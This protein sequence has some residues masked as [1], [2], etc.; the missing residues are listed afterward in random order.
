MQKEK[1]YFV[2]KYGTKK[3]Y[4]DNY[5]PPQKKEHAESPSAVPAYHRG[6]MKVSEKRDKHLDLARELKTYTT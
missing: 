4:N 3:N 2:L 1:N 5:P 6:K